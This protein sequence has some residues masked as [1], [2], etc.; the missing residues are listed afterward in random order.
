MA[1]TRKCCICLGRGQI[2][3]QP[4]CEKALS[5]CTI[6]HDRSRLNSNFYMLLIVRFSQYV[7]MMLSKCDLSSYQ[8]AMLTRTSLLPLL[9]ALRNS[10]TNT[11]S[12]LFQPRFPL[13]SKHYVQLPSITGSLTSSVPASSSLPRAS[14][15]KILRYLAI[16]GAL[17][18]NPVCRR[19]SSKL[20]S[21]S[22]SARATT[23][24]SV[25]DGE[26]GL[27][28]PLMT[29]LLTVGN[30]WW[31]T[32]SLRVLGIYFIK[33]LQSRCHACNILINFELQCSS[34][35]SVTIAVTLIT[36]SKV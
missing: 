29:A 25:L 34:S 22:S 26:Q 10:A 2:C 28:M 21:A 27:G 24:R 19:A 36:A 14:L 32:L 7:L 5:D 30:R 12:S 16:A 4:T 8:H 23:I 18:I 20:C 31:H 9:R 11:S 35:S 33:Q 15:P 3:V 17:V 6:A 1:H 13:S